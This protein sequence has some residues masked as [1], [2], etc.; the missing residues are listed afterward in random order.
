MATDELLAGS[1][2]EGGGTVTN[3]PLRDS[4]RPTSHT[5]TTPR[6]SSLPFTSTPDARK[7][8]PTVAY[9][10]RN[11]A[12]HFRWPIREAPTLGFCLRPSV[13]TLGMSLQPQR[14]TN[15]IPYDNC[16]IYPPAL[17]PLRCDASDTRNKPLTRRHLSQTTETMGNAFLDPAL[18]SQ[19]I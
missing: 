11:H 19:Y 15:P 13:S 7:S 5:S 4:L 2:L 18:R 14:S 3:T 1:K 9:L 8:L 6:P 10:T 17:L 12:D 16:L